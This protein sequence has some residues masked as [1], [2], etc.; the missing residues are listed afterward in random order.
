MTESPASAESTAE[1]DVVSRETS[2]GQVSRETE[3]DTPIAREAA[4]AV[5]VRN[6]RQEHWPR[7]PAT[8]VVT[9]ANQKG[10]VGKTTTAVNL[11][12]LATPNSGSVFIVATMSLIFCSVPSISTLGSI[13]LSIVNLARPT[14][15]E[16]AACFRISRIR[17]RSLKSFRCGS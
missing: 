2:D 1:P 4:H 6:V 14:S 15:I 12:A 11:A 9:V 7:P 10:G 3:L 13:I 16:S 8:R 17:V 5:Q